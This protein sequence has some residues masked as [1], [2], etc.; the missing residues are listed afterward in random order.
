MNT[1]IHSL[2]GGG[3]IAVAAGIAVWAA[4]P[5]QPASGHVLLLDND[6]ILE[7]D[8]TRDGDRYHIKGALSETWV[9]AAKA[10]RLCADRAD[11]YRFLRGRANLRDV[12]ERLR[13][14]RWCHLHGLRRQALAEAEAALELRPTNAEAKRLVAS[15]K[16]PIAPTPAPPKNEPEVAAGP[17]PEVT[18]EALGMFA[19]KVQPILMNTCAS[20]HIAN[21]SGSAF[22]LA[23]AFGDAAA[24]QR[25][26]QQN[27][28]AAVA[29]I[30]RDNWQASPLLI[31]AISIHGQTNKP[32][33]KSR[34]VQA[35]HTLEEW[36]R[37][38]AT[39][40]P[41]EAT[42]TDARR[43]AV[44]PMTPADTQPAETPTAENKELKKVN[45]PALALKPV[46]PPA[47]TNAATKPEE[48]AAA[49]LPEKPADPFDPDIFN[50][51]SRQ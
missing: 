22:K 30:H 43:A 51:Q 8:V 32:P 21:K 23:R 42:A 31:K 24:N 40:L 33:L 3:L 13:L 11:V 39:N 37:L 29:H 19:A 14:A 15:L 1:F 25:S 48:K 4:E 10:V 2:I 47:K 5:A 46:P 36:V 6:R 28:A 18:L 9:P 35:Y 16:K 27:L 45:D 17:G 38:I 49:V 34:Q 12:D 44:V 20:C 26:T 7:G 50:R 41:P